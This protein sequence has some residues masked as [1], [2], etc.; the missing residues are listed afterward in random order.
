MVKYDI[1]FELPRYRFGSGGIASTIELVHTIKRIY[2]HLNIH[3]R[4]QKQQPGIDYNSIGLKVSHSIGLPD[5][6][7]PATDWGITYTD[8]PFGINLSRLPQVNNISILMLSYGMAPD[9]EKANISIDKIKI[10]CSTI[11][12][13]N[14]LLKEGYTATQVGF[15]VNVNNFYQEPYSKDKKI[16][17]LLRHSSP[18]K[19]YNMGVNIC[20]KLYSSKYI[21]EVITFGASAHNDT[22]KNPR[23]L[24]QHFSDATPEQIRHIF[25]KASIFIM[26]SIVEGLSRTPI[27]STLCGCPAVLCDGALEDIY[28]PEKNCKWA[29]KG[30]EPSFLSKSI[31]ILKEDHSLSY[32]T[33]MEERV[34]NFTWDNTAKKLISALY[35]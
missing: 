28:F 18:E 9:R 13:K 25:S 26:P 3:I 5:K 20:D 34:K 6:D 22:D 10:L 32:R 23:A 33:D 7:F 1:V 29:L 30:V 27:E 35:E 8:T 21:D 11:R 31:E 4:F 14:L 15:G 24:S 16:A 2:P 12:T 19:N 17:V